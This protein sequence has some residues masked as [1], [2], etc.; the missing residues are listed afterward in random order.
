[1]LMKI[2]W[3]SKAKSDL[4]GIVE[5]LGKESRNTA[6]RKAKKIVAA[7]RHLQTMPRIGE[8]LAQFAPNEIRRILIGQYEVRYQIRESMVIILRIRHTREH[9]QVP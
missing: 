7:V 8:Q 2:Q 1:M 5:F 9:R 3:H 4:A 6:Q